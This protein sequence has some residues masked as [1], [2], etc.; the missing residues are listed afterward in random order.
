MGKEIVALVTVLD[1]LKEGIGILEEPFELK[2]VMVIKIR[3]LFEI[4]RLFHAVDY[5]M[6]G[7]FF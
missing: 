3:C 2:V 4:E 6:N 7:Y 1:E 5:A